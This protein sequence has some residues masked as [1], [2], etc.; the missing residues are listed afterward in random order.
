MK[1]VEFFLSE[2]IKKGSLWRDTIEETLKEAKRMVMLYTDKSYD[3]NWCLYEAILYCEMISRTDQK[4]R[5]LYCIHYPDSP[6]P[7]PLRKLQAIK[8]TSDDIS[9]WLENIFEITEQPPDSYNL[10]KAAHSL[11]ATS[12]K[13][14]NLF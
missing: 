9:L 8:S 11:K 5:K 1:N 3:W 13:I 6:P 10:P 4:H 12:L 2:K 14:S 7:D